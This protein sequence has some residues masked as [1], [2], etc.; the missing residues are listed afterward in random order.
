MFKKDAIDEDKELSRLQ[1][2]FLDAVGPL[3]AAF[4]ELG[5][6]EPDADHTCAAMQQVLPIPAPT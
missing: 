5:K 6:E 1:S 2:F 3:V 4:E